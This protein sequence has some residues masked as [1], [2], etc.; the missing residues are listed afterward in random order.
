[1]SLYFVFFF[2]LQTKE[3]IIIFFLLNQSRKNPP[4]IY[5]SEKFLVGKNFITTQKKKTC[6]NRYILIITFLSLIKK[7]TKRK[8]RINTNLYAGPYYLLLLK[9]AKKTIPPQQ[10]KNLFPFLF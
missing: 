2:T 4:H 10:Q 1:M 6:I 8:N 5:N 3:I 7:K 9:Y